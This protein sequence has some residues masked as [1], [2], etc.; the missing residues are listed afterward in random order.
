MD[1]RTWVRFAALA[2]LVLSASLAFSQ[3]KSWQQVPIPPLPAFHPQEPTRI[4]LPNGLVIY[5]QEDHELPLINGVAYI[6]GGSRDES[7]AKTGLA[8]LYG[9]VWRTGGTTSRTGDQLDDFLEARAARVETGADEDSTSVSFSCLKPDFAPVFEI[10]ADLLLHPAFREE[11]LDLA[12]F[13]AYTAISRRN[14]DID[15]IVGRESVRLAYGKDNP[16]AR[17]EEY[18]TVAAV[19]RQDLLD[20]HDKYVHPNDMILGIV[21]DFDTAQ[22]EASLRQAF[23]AWTKGPA[24]AA[25]DVAFHDPAPGIYFAAKPDVDQSAISMVYLGIE[26]RNPDYYALEVMNQI[27]GGGF[28]SRLFLNIRS[29]MGLA[30]SVGGGVGSDWDHP[31]IFDASMGT[32]SSTTAQGVNALRAQMRDMLT[33]PATEKELST[34]KDTLLNNFI[35]NL[36][37]KVKVLRARMRYEFYGYPSDWLERYPP[38]IRKVTAADVLRVAKKYVHPDKVATLIVGNPQEMGS[39]LEQL[40]KVTTLDISIPPPPPGL[41]PGSPGDKQ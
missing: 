10:F 24:Y 7:A 35:F 19:T 38:N 37:S 33:R 27:F 21:G 16:Y 12:K 30:Y 8:G 28:A 25:P 20:W 2:A 26:R 3:A 5:L 15:D 41:L 39:Q 36:D 40:G 17:V 31:G 9:S 11:K 14:D 13:R 29:K 32:K 6:H 23:G 22:M 1:R 4:V 18:S 34:A